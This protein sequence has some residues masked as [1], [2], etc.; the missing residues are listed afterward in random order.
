MK[1][2]SYRRHD[3]LQYEAEAK[4]LED[5]TLCWNSAENI[6]HKKHIGPC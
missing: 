5:S 6:N 3:S 2:S 1:R 4:S